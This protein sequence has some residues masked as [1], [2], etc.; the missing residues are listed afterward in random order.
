MAR[1]VQFS[2]LG[3]PEVLEF[4]DAETP[5]PGQ[6][7]VQI[8]MKAAGLNRAELLFM[9]GAYL[10]PP[11]PPSR[12]GFEGAGEIVVAPF[13][14]TRFQ[15]PATWPFTTKIGLKIPFPVLACRA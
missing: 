10:L 8:A 3:G 6:G 9:A 14:G 11:V 15:V 4:I 13:F 5:P 7:E 12:L 2:A 1:H